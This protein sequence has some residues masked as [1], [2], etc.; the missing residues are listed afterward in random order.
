MLTNVQTFV[1][2]EFPNQE[3]FGSIVAA[4]FDGDMDILDGGSISDAY[5]VYENDGAGNFSQQAKFQGPI[6]TSPSITKTF[7]KHTNNK[8]HAFC[9]RFLFHSYH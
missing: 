8:T 6:N 3:G 1:R 2:N 7:T 4:D 5:Y 9:K